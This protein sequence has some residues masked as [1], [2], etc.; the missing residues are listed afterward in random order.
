MKCAFTVFRN[1]IFDINNSINK[2]MQEYILRKR[3]AVS[4]ISLLY[5]NVVK[6][7][8]LFLKVSRNKLVF[9]VKWKKAPVFPKLS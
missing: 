4:H 5:C 6:K 3:N 2:L 1:I 9:D 7:I 8:C